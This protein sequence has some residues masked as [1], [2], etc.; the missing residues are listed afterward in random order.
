MERLKKMWALLMVLVMFAVVPVS[1][2]GCKKEN[3]QDKAEKVLKD[4]KKD[5]EDA[6]K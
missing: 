1:L 3:E 5:A 4:V 6:T 2:S